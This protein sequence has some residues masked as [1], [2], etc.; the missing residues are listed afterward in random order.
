MCFLAHSRVL[1]PGTEAQQP[2]APVPR[3]AVPVWD[4]A[5]SQGLGRRLTGAG[6]GN[7]E[8]SPRGPR[9]LGGRN[10]GA[11]SRRGAG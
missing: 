7:S 5:E 10:P 1:E 4:P 2:S 6:A 8:R 11:C 9:C 3:C